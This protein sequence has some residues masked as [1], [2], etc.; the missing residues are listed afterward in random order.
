MSLLMDALRKAEAA[1]QQGAEPQSPTPDELTLEPIPPPA[2]SPLPDLAQH[3]DS[4]G[5]DLAAMPA[6]PPPRGSRTGPPNGNARRD[7]AEREAARNLFAVKEAPASRLPLW[8]FLG[9]A[10]TAALG[11][12][13]Y[14]WWQ[15]Q[16]LP[17]RP[18]GATAQPAAPVPP[19]RPRPEAAAPT[20]NATAPAASA[21]TPAHA[22]LG[23][24]PPA[25]RPADPAM[26]EA[27]ATPVTRVDSRRTAVP[28]TTEAPIRIS[29]ERPTVSPA[30][31]RAYAALLAGRLD[32]ARRD[33]E[34]V[35]HGDPK[36]VDALLGLATI[37]LREGRSDLAEG[38][39]LSALESDPLN[40]H[41]QAALLNLGGAPS[42][43]QLSE[44]RLKS[45]LAAQPDS[46]PLEFALGN[47]YA[48][49]G[50]WSEAQQ[51]YFRAF[52]G[53][54]DNADYLYN[55]AVSLDHLRQATLAAQ[56]YRQALAAAEAR[57]AAFE[58]APVEA[59]LRQLQP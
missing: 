50:R 19:A 23:A 12:A 13:G 27:A 10:G 56:Y 30:L 32:D 57:G 38:Y 1:K 4:V 46:P 24:T 34:R 8:L 40:Q 36:H 18:L 5:A 29:R 52:S 11:I 54:P 21:T 37:A 7:E 55:L 31:G 44:S 25:I 51:S 42:D 15:L 47:L 53:E 35:L 14:F 22:G 20:R 6:T 41:A 9:L 3:L 39:F 28:A 45:L 33:Y 43:P 2:T 58:R 26:P 16:A 48:R 17:G 49:Q 59:R